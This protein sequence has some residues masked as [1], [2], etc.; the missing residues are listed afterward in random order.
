MLETPNPN[1]T[2]APATTND[3]QEVY[4]CVLPFFHIYGF[5]VLLM[6]RMSVG[7]K[8]VTLPRF[9]PNSFLNSMTEHKG[10][11][12]SLVPPILQFMINDSRCT[13]EKMP[14]LRT[15]VS[16]AAPIGTD[17]V[18]RFKETK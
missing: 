11:F 12:L 9:E 5:T 15:V 7:A 8:L 14:Y 10:T 13:S 6:S 1:H 17:T 2:L 16:G 18:N 3:H 4:P